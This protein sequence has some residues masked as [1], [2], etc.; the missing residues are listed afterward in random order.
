RV[1]LPA[2]A[3]PRTAD[4]GAGRRGLAQLAGADQLGGPGQA[5]TAAALRAQLDHAVVLA[6]GL[7][8][9]PAFAE[10]VA[11]RLFHVDVLAGLAGPDRGQRVPVV[12]R[13]HDDRVEGLVLQDPAQV[14]FDP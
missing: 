10:V 12:G 2:D 6:G 9:A 11:G 4:P 8:H 3:G 1:R 7:D 14:L 13:G 5:G